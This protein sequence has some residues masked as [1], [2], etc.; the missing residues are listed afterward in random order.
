VH[1]HAFICKLS[2]SSQRCT[3]EQPNM[4]PLLQAVPW[5]YADHAKHLLPHCYCSL[6]KRTRSGMQCAVVCTTCAVHRLLLATRPCCTTHQQLGACLQWPGCPPAA[7][8]APAASRGHA[9]PWCLTQA[10]AAA[11][12]AAAASAA[13]AAATTSLPLLLPPSNHSL[14]IKCVPARVSQHLH[15]GAMLHTAPLHQGSCGACC[16][17]KCR[18]RTAGAGSQSRLHN[19]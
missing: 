17:S 6:Y 1:G 18:H 4:T 8:Q 14:V 2:C 5:V 7:P 10:A 9:L 12:A 11:A 3:W 15:Y 19:K 13:G 16:H